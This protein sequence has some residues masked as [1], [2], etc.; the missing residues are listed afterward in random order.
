MVTTPGFG[1]HSG[2]SWETSPI[3]IARKIFGNSSERFVVVKEFI[4]SALMDIIIST[5]A[6]FRAYR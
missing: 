5:D 2:V 1:E 4:Y 3:D 6:Y